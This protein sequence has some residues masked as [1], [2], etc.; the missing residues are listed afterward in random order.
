M[1]RRPSTSGRKRRSSGAV[2]A[3]SRAFELP[4]LCPR[5]RRIC[6]RPSGRKHFTPMRRSLEDGDQHL[7]PP[8]PPPCERAWCRLR[9]HPR[10]SPYWDVTLS[11]GAPLRAG[12]VRRVGAMKY[13]SQARTPPPGSPDP[14]NRCRTCRPGQELLRLHGTQMRRAARAGTGVRWFT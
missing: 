4:R 5:L 3:S 10:T 7:T 13:R 1:A 2:P 6:S 12:V 14:R 11:W 8:S 9:S